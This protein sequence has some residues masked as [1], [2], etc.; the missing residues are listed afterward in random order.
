MILTLPSA[1]RATDGPSDAVLLG[2][3]SIGQYIRPEHAAPDPR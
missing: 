3:R 2:E 1:D